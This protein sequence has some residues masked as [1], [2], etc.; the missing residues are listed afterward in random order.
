MLGMGSNVDCWGAILWLD[1]N[2]LLL[3]LVRDAIVYLYLAFV[4]YSF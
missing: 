3:D 1:A 2:S 4:C